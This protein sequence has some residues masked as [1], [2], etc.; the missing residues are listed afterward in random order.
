MSVFRKLICLTLFTFALLAVQESKA[1][2]AAV[3]TN[4]VYD[5]LANVNAG[6]EVGLAPKWTLDV[7]GNFNG[8][9]MSHDRKW[10]HWLVQPELRYWF[11]DRF[12]GHFLGLHL[13]GGQYNVGG[14]KNSIEFLGTDFSKLSDHRFQGWFAGAGIAYGYTWVL[15]RH[16]NLEAEI[17]IGYSYSVSDKFECVGCGRKVEEDKD[18]HYVGPTKAAINLVYVF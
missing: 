10:K 3:K 6:V 15:G 4:L 18:H 17:G 13:H 2:N 11:C 8:W 1:Q 12:A 7:S 16:W 5:A 9:D 14:L